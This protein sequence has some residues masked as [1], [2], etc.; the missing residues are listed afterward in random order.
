MTAGSKELE[1]AALNRAR[2][3]FH[4]LHGNITAVMRGQDRAVRFVLAAF[5]A[6]GHVLLEDVPGT[7]KTTLGKSL[8]ASLQA[9]FTRVQFTPDLLPADILGVSVYD[10]ARQSFRFHPGPVFT[11]ILLG[12]EINR[13]S[14][15]TQS[16]LLEAMAERQ[17]SVEGRMMELKPPFFVIATQ[18][19]SDFHGTYP[20]PESQMDRFAMSFQLGYVEPE[21]EAT[22]LEAQVLGHPLDTLKPCAT[23]DDAL[24]LMHGAS[25]VRVSPELTRYMVD[26]AAATRTEPGVRLGAGP[27]ASLTLMRCAQ[28]LSLADGHDFVIPDAVQ[29]AAPVVLPHRIVLESQAEYAGE[30][31][32]AVVG[33]LL[34]SIPVPA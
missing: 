16:A 30:T 14:P 26:L 17:V 25:L 7:G 8:A 3:V 23:L 31:A 28:A 15:R 18:N 21:I 13:A 33:R 19:P 5:A 27:R 24:A 4:A 2:A 34:E 29:E 32:H 20:L 11:N 9:T 6:G 22:V 10:P 1:D 12:D